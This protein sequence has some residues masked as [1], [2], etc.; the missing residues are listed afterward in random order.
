M[1]QT[2]GKD[3]IL[4]AT[5]SSG[6]IS[7]SISTPVNTQHTEESIAAL[8]RERDMLRSQLAEI[9]VEAHNLYLDFG[10][11]IL[12]LVSFPKLLITSLSA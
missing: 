8:R 12:S 10:Q 2:A 3:L 7:D 5:T 1:S 9:Q 11:M 6:L 4:S